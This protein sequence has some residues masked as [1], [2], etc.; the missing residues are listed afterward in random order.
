MFVLFAA[1]YSTLRPKAEVY[2]PVP[3]PT[4]ER[5]VYVG[6]WVGGSWESRTK[7]LDVGA[8]NNFQ[9][10]IQKK[11]AIVNIF[12]EWTYLENPDLVEDLKELDS[13][14]WVPMISAN[15]YFFKECEDTGKNLYKTIAD[16]GCDEFL[17]SAAKNL[18]DYK[19]PV[20]L[21]FAWEMNLPNMYWSVDK[22]GSS[23]TD[24]IAAWRHFYDIA[25]KA[26][27]NIIWVLSF[28]TSHTGTTPYA[29]LYPGDEYVDWVAIDGYNWGSGHSFG[30][31]ASFDG[32]FRKSY[33]EL[34]AITKKPVMISEV[35]SA[36]NGGD[37]AEWLKD[38][39]EE[40]IINNYP[41]VGA[42]ILFNENKSSGES[43]DWRIEKSEDYINAVRQGLSNTIYAR[44]YP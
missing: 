19:K 9:D 4:P 44:S 15:P 30:G 32:T 6:A 7:T 27:D 18:S 42:L 14:G 24:F 23:P 34:T 1:T 21:R 17:L 31:W 20:M 38:M 10:I 28:N 12:S 22:V 8:I 3:E 26:A 43:V 39:L 25:Q 29:E 2:S 33:D 41:E 5:K 40:Q 37:K 13:E 36:P 35:N 16:G 11:L